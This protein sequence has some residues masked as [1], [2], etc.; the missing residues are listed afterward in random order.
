[1]MHPAPIRARSRTWDWFQMLVPAPISASGATSA[2]G[3]M[4]TDGRSFMRSPAVPRFYA[5]ASD[6]LGS[7]PSVGQGSNARGGRRDGLSAVADT[8]LLLWSQLCGGDSG[9]QFEDR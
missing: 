6:R 1:M 9:R 3:W 7:S 4:R 5:A 2:V 8:V